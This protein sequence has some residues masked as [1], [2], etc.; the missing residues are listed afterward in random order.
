[1]LFRSTSASQGT[2][3]STFTVSVAVDDF[4]DVYLAMTDTGADTEFV[5][6]NLTFSGCT[7]TDIDAN[8][9]LTAGD[10]PVLIAPG[11]GAAVIFQDGNL[12]V[13][14]T[15]GAGSDTAGATWPI[16]NNTIASVTDNFYAA[17]T[18][19]VT[20]WLLTVSGTTATNFYTLGLPSYSDIDTDVTGTGT[21]SIYC[22]T[23]TDCKVAY[24]DATDGDITFADCNNAACSAPTITDIDTDVGG[25]LNPGQASIY[26]PA[27]D[28]CKVVYFD[29]TDDD[30]TFA[31]CANA[32]CS[33]F[34]GG[35]PLDIDT[36]V[37]TGKVSI[38]CPTATDC[39]VAYTDT[40]DDDVT[41]ADCNDAACSAP[42]ITDI[43]IDVGNTGKTS[44]YCPTA[45]DCKVAYV[46]STD[47]DI[48]FVDCNDAACYAAA[49]ATAPF[50]GETNL[51]SVS[52]TY[53]STNSE[54]YAH[55]IKDTSEQAYFKSTDAATIS[56]G[57]ETSYVFTAGD[58]GH[59]SAP[60]TGTGTTDI[61][62]VLRQGANF[63]FATVPEKSLYLI[64]T[65]PLLYS[66]LKKLKERETAH[67]LAKTA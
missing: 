19:A 49:S 25:A 66:I 29:N 7:F 6:F 35:G 18:D 58:L 27:A 9:G 11:A 55:V 21:V 24:F 32:A 63:E 62:V 42:T 47:G 3:G 54:L 33:S 43:D 44:I 39:K 15:E 16:S 65:T 30:I 41:F 45:T 34:D 57:T 4:G 61:G 17:T 31:D 40:T 53:D 1:M 23:A 8:S 52:I 14:I 56:W 10:R 38:Y 2:I 48:T 46:D 13:S 51:T 67:K 36:D 22:P 26:C 28:D 60:M 64:L 50:S 20:T 5:I 37:G 59:I 12:S